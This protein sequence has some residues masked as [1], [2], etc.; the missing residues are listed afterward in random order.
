MYV[1]ARYTQWRSDNQRRYTEAEVYAKKREFRSHWD[2]VVSK[3]KRARETYEK[4]SRD[5][6]ARQPRI[7]QDLADGLNTG[8]RT[9]VQ[10]SNWIRNWCGPASIQR[11]L[12]SHETY[13]TYR[14][15]IIP[16]LSKANSDK[17][18]VFSKNVLNHW[19][20]PPSTKVLWVMSDEKWFH[21]LVPRSLHKAC[22]EIGVHKTFHSAHHKN[23]ITK[24]MGHATVGF[25]FEGGCPENGGEGL[26]IALHRC[27]AHKVYQKDVHYSSKDAQ[28]RTRFK[29]NPIKH[30]K[31]TAVLV[32]ANVTGVD[33]GTATNPKFALKDLWEHSL[34]PTI[35]QLVAPG[36]KYEGYTVVFQEDNAGPHE[37]R[38]YSTWLEEEFT[39]RGWLVRLQAPQ[40]PYTNVLDLAVFPG[41]SKRHSERLQM[42]NNTVATKDKIW[43]TAVDVWDATT[44]ADV[45]RGFVQAYRV[46]G[47]IIHE[48][49]NNHWLQNGGPHCNVRRDFVDTLSGVKNKHIASF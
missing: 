44:S 45:A 27:Q 1:N 5:H 11:W 26:L 3:D 8:I 34:F 30:K 35:D 16:G 49:G 38:A 29:G 19:G 31:H 10:L 22:P 36:G 28:G 39:K 20:L 40:G 7:A 41:M 25:A 43:S 12:T 37:G 42:F 2:E 13:S 17:Q 15:N 48:G 23:H 9:W 6:D 18:V 47:R 46:M 4:K 14:K 32:D 21:G 24:V 33:R